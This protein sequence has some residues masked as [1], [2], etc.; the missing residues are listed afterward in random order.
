MILSHRSSAVST[1]PPC[2]LRVV[3]GIRVLTACLLTWVHQ[4]AHSGIAGYSYSLGLCSCSTHSVASLLL[5]FRQVHDASWGAASS[6]PLI[7]WWL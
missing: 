7:T 1:I 5:V 4:Q 2:R 3:K 6:V